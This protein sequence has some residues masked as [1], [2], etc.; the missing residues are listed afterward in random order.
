MLCNIDEHAGP[1]TVRHGGVKLLRI[2]ITVSCD[3]EKCLICHVH[4][5]DA[6]FYCHSPYAV[7]CFAHLFISVDKLAQVPLRL[8]PFLHFPSIY[9][10]IHIVLIV[11]CWRIQIL[12]TLLK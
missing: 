10:T 6:A 5:D 11:Y 9:I 4:Y 2:I 7:A 8:F 1:T 12:Q 3:I